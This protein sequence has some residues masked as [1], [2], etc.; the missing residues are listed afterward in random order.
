MIDGAEKY[1][2]E[3]AHE[4]RIKLLNEHFGLKLNFEDPLNE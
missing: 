4:L 3:K 2:S 1:V